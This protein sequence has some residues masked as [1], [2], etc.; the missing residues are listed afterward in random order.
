MKKSSLFIVVMLFSFCFPLYSQG[1]KAPPKVKKRKYSTQYHHAR[2]NGG[3]K[4]ESLSPDWNDSRINSLKGRIEIIKEAF[5]KCIVNLVKC[6]DSYASSLLRPNKTK[7]V[8]G[9][10]YS[11]LSGGGFVYFAPMKTF[12]ELLR[13]GN[14]IWQHR[15]YDDGLNSF[16]ADIIIKIDYVQVLKDMSYARSKASGRYSVTDR[17]DK[18]HAYKIGKDEDE[19]YSFEIEIFPPVFEDGKYFIE[20]ENRWAESPLEAIEYIILHELGHLEVYC[21]KKLQIK[22]LKDLHSPVM[23]HDNSDEEE[24][25]DFFAT[26][27]L[28]C[29]QN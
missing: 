7:P 3:I 12:D 13:F 22:L 24:F 15:Y 11:K 6:G 8:D 14:A 16:V 4:N 1:L 26:S 25:A 10:N 28:S 9:E 18:T 17:L 23:T 2:Y 5:K 19:H 20:T 27:I 29:F 21:S